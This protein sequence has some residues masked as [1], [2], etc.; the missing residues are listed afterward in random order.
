VHRLDPLANLQ[1][2]GSDFVLGF[3]PGMKNQKQS[4]TTKL[5]DEKSDPETIRLGF[6]SRLYKT[7]LSWSQASDRSLKLYGQAAFV[8]NEWEY[9]PYYFKWPEN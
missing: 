9:R 4:L 2:R 5:W 3:S 7:S 1:A 8:A 6:T